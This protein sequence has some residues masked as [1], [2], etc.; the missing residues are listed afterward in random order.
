M[1][2]Q[3]H[4]NRVA[5]WHQRFGHVSKKLVVTRQG[6]CLSFV[7]QLRILT[8]NIVSTGRRIENRALPSEYDPHGDDH[9]IQNRFRTQWRKQLAANGVDRSARSRD[10]MY[11]AL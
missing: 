11:L 4:E 10:G 9:I 8:C 1:G 5:P 2:Y 6:A 7:F 3:L